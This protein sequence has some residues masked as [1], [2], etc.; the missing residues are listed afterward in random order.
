MV[1]TQVTLVVLALLAGSGA[2]ATSNPIVTVIGQNDPANDRQAIQDAIDTA[3]PNS[4]IRLVGTFA[5]DGERILVQTSDLHIVGEAVD[6]DGDSRYQEDWVDGR[7][8]DNDGLI[9]EDDWE[10][11]LRGVSTP[12]GEPATDNGV[13]GLFNRAFAIEGADVAHVLVRD[14][15]FT[16]FHRAIELIP[17]W[18][19]PTG[20]CDDRVRV[21]AEAQEVRIE[22]NRFTDNVLGVTMLGAVSHS[23]I[24]H[25][26]FERNDTFGA[27]VEG[28]SVTCPLTGGGGV[29]LNLTSPSA[30]TLRNNVGVASGLGTAFTEQ[31]RVQGNRLEDSIFGHVSI[32]DQGAKIQDNLAYDC[33][34]AFILEG[35]D[36]VHVTGNVAVA[37]V[38]GFDLANAA[39]GVQVTENRVSGGLLGITV[40]P[41]G[42]GYRVVDNRFDASGFVDVYLTTGSSDNVVINGEGPPITVLD[43]GTDNRLVG[44]I[45]LF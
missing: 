34:L 26:V 4:T 27:V 44:K 3:S 22:R 21:D 24:E 11:V 42:S 16:T 23:S 43:S 39:H 10:T 31:S 25:N 19:S 2:S 35:G 5:L 17:E 12:D 30:V 29:V 37:P 9:D 13:N 14:L 36:K 18:A 45:D 1:R 32:H 15:H 20:R 6:D 41:N 40:E 38:I 7:D 8:N 33:V 28:G